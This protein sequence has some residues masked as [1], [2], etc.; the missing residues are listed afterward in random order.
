[1]VRRFIWFWRILLLLLCRYSLV[2]YLKVRTLLSVGMVHNQRT[3]TN[4]Q[5]L[6][7]LSSSFSVGR[8]DWLDRLR[9]S[10]NI[11]TGGWVF[12]VLKTNNGA[13]F[14]SFARLVFSPFFDIR[15]ILGNIKEKPTRKTCF[16]REMKRLALRIYLAK[17][18]WAVFLWC[19]R[20]FFCNF[21][22]K[23]CWNGGEYVKSFK[24]ESLH[25]K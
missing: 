15:G 5:W 21:M 23:R 4:E 10:S 16:C 9:Y 12:P 1:M 14:P 3:I 18:C 11:E 13:L 25:A 19:Q 20:S 2:E 17:F 7:T 24:N 6:L 22:R 8:R